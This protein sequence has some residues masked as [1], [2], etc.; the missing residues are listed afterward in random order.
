MKPNKDRVSDAVGRLPCLKLQWAE[1]VTMKRGKKRSW[2]GDVVT[3]L[4]VGGDHQRNE[5]TI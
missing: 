1:N 3:P 4:E 2:S 5:L